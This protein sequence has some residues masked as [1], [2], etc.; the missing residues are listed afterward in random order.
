M[1]SNK[2]LLF[3]ILRNIKTEYT[4]DELIKMSLVDKDSE[5]KDIYNVDEYSY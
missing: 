1:H 4:K 5:L 3:D 2:N